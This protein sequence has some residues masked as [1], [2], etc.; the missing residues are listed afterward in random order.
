MP[1]IS[2]PTA[3]S[4]SVRDAAA[5]TS[6]SE[7]EIRNAINSGHLEARRLGRRIVILTDD[8]KAW[9]EALPKVG[10]VA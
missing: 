3:L 7:Y 5:S 8:L 9:L 10:D 6:L 1:D 2:Y 4:I